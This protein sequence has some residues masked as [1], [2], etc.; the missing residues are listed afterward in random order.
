MQNFD[1]L[2]ARLWRERKFAEISAEARRTQAACAAIMVPAI[3]LAIG[4]YSVSV[5]PVMGY[6]YQ[7]TIWMFGLLGAGVAAMATI[8]WSGGM[9]AMT[10][11]LRA[12]FL[13]TSSILIAGIAFNLLLVPPLGLR[14]AAWAAFL[15]M[16]ATV[17]IHRYF[18]KRHIGLDLL[19]YA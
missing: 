1:P 14:G 6:E 3:V 12:N 18:I 8:V 13:R 15:H 7:Q 5:T 10:G 2:V 16:L 9:L 11:F 17:G 19:R 4:V